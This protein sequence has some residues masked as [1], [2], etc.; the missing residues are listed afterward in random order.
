MVH[1]HV[2]V[3][4]YSCE[5]TGDFQCSR[6][7]HQDR[8]RF[9]VA[10]QGQATVGATSRD[11]SDVAAERAKKI[12]AKLSEQTIAVLSCPKCQQMNP[13]SIG[14]F[15]R[16]QALIASLFALLFAAGAAVA[17]AAQGASPLLWG[18]PTFVLTAVLLCVGGFRT[19]RGRPV[20]FA[21]GARGGQP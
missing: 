13:G 3:A 17:A 4:D 10:T 11:S 8:Y 6:C 7:G 21:S 16:G 1:Y 12:A 5:V 14:R 19:A 15:V 9:T 2:S 20:S 18:A